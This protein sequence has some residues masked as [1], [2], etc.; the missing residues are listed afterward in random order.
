MMTKTTDNL[1]KILQN[2]QKWNLIK[3]LKERMIIL[4][5]LTKQL[6]NWIIILILNNQ[7]P[8]KDTKYKT[9]K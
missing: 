7:S 1:C 8:S 4:R 2:T 6:K 5:G 3:G 9:K